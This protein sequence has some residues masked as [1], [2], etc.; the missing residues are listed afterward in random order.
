[1]SVPDQPG[2]LGRVAVAMGYAGADI[3]EVVVLERASG[4][5][6]DDFIVTWPDAAPVSSLC[7]ELAGIDGAHVAG[8][9]HLAEVP[10][11][12]VDT[13]VFGGLREP[14]DL[15]DLVPGAFSADWAVLVDAGRVERASRR[16]PEPFEPP[17]PRDD[18][19]HAFTAPG[20]TRYAAVPLAGRTLLAARVAAPPFHAAEVG[21]LAVLAAAVTTVA[22]TACES[23]LA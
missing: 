13:A 22:R 5:A 9:W 6:L 18:G 11:P 20:G 8:V 19:P 15:V 10:S 3:L 23:S 12:H 16:A 21:R 2:A 14:A 7:D 1:M 4:R 17:R